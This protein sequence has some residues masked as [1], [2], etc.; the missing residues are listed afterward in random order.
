MAR[1]RR[2]GRAL[3]SPNSYGLI[4]VLLIVTYV[5]S[6]SLEGHPRG[7]FILVIQIVTVWLTLQVAHAHKTTRTMSAIALVLAFGVAI[8]TAF[9]GET[10]RANGLVFLT[11]S[12]L[13]FI[14][15]LAILRAIAKRRDVDLETVLGAIDAYLFVGMF[16]AY[17]YQAIGAFDPPLFQGAAGTATV[18]QTLFFSFTTLT[19]T[20]YGNLVPATDLGQT[21]SV[22]EMLI[23]Q[24]FLITAVAKVITAWR[25]TRWAAPDGGGP[26]PSD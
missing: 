3:T 26:E 16:F 17:S 22:A 13:Y 18:A 10:D 1:H 20:G 24:L 14:A 4:L 8:G 15:P 2:L 7:S 6:V 23:G 9:A 21:V 5:L 19:T 25:P 11:A 12:V